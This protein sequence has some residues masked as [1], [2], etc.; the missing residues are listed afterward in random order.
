MSKPFK[1]G[2]VGSGGIAR[3]HMKHLQTIPGVEIACA[4]DVNPQ[5]LQTAQEQYKV[6]RIYR[7]FSEMLKKEKD[8]DAIDVCTPNSLHAP[9]AIAAL[10]AG[11]HVLVEKPMA[12][13]A[14]QA[15]S[16]V[17]AAKRAKK[18]LIIGFQ[19]R[20]D[21]RTELIRRQI[22]EGHF[23]KIMF[24]RCQALRRRGIP[25]WGV[26]GQKQLQGGGP[27]IDIG[28][29]V[30]EMAHYAI[31]SPKPLAASGNIWTY[32]GNK[33]S[34]TLCTWPNWDWKT[35]DVEDLAVGTIRLEGGAMLSIEASFV[36]H[37]EQDIWSFQVMGEKG[38][39]TWEPIRIF[40]DQCGHMMNISPAW[41]GKVGWDAIWEVKMKHFVDVC[42]EGRKNLAPGEHGVMIQKMLDGVYASAAK[43]REVQIG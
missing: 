19:F 39:A 12:M 41:I 20:F 5:S 42:R 36:A 14:R 1:V 26:F 31:G 22:A 13:N 38:G 8:L 35:Y 28:V 30:M 16:M 32:H 27:M 11:K 37:L 18:E 7:D 29:H 40:T 34:D 2:F 9:N 17:D 33:P 3:T 15:Q 23:G 43:G 25:N 10:R 21:P 24:V 6:A 4:A